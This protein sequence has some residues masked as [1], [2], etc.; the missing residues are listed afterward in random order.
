MSN[1][2]QPEW[3]ETKSQEFLEERN[4]RKS[5]AL[6]CI[7][8][9]SLAAAFLAGRA[10]SGQRLDIILFIVSIVLLAAGTVWFRIAYLS[11][12][13]LKRRAGIPTEDDGATAKFA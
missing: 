5:W 7:I 6:V 11:Q 3:Y 4:E 13:E 1:I 12:E 2:W 9:V 10:T 8:L